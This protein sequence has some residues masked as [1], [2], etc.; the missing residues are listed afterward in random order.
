MTRKRKSSDALI[1]LADTHTPLFPHALIVASVGVSQCLTV[2]IFEKMPMVPKL[3]MD[4]LT[5]VEE[6]S[7]NSDWVQQLNS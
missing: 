1:D 5:G 2:Q 3:E 4:I 7:M 6:N